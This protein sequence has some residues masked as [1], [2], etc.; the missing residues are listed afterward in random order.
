MSVFHL[1]QFSS[2]IV[3]AVHQPVDETGEKFGAGNSFARYR[4]EGLQFFSVCG[5]SLFRVIE[6]G[7]R[8]LI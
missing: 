8:C 2:R 5:C 4:L 6:S 1:S 3:K 7:E